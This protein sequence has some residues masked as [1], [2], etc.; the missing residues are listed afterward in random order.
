VKRIEFTG[1]PT[2]RLNNTLRAF[3]SLPLRLV[4]H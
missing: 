3:G 4:P 2:R 1:E